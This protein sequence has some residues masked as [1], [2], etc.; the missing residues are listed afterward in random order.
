MG[1]NSFLYEVCNTG[2]R[3]DEL[4]NYKSDV[5]RIADMSKGKT[6]D[7][8]YRGV[9]LYYQIDNYHYPI[10]L[11]FNTLFDRQMNNWLHDSLYKRNY[12]DEVGQ[13]MR[14]LYEQG[15]IRTESEFKDMIEEVMVG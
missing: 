11:Q 9:H 10:E 13:K 8:G 12:P 14:K 7:D 4:L 2:Y 5:F 6:K 15:G 3:Y 1:Y